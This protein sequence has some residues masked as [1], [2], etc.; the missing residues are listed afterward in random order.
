MAEMKRAGE[1]LGS[2]QDFDADWVLDDVAEDFVLLG[3]E[4]RE[5]GFGPAVVLLCERDGEQHRW[6][7]WS[8]VIIDQVHNLADELPV[9]AR[10]ESNRGDQGWY[11]T[12]V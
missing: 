2:Q 8:V 10:V 12:L 1:V 7:T 4:E 9:L 3:F 11:Y 5:T 6:V